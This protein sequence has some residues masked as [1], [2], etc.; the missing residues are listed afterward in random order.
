MINELFATTSD[1]YLTLGFCDDEPDNLDTADGKPRTRAYAAFRLARLIGEDGTTLA[2][3]DIETIAEAVYSAQLQM[4]SEAMKKV[5]VRLKKSK[6]ERILISGHGDFL[7]ADA[8]DLLKW[9][10]DTIPLSRRISDKIA[11]C[12]PS[13]A[14]AILASEQIPSL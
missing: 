12:A 4:V 2:K 9:K 1:A 3:Q 6:P 5:A 10:M 11:R 13:H 14:V 7:V 8:L